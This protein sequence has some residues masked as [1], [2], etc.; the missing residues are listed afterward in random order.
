MKNILRFRLVGVMLVLV[1]VF[2]ETGA[3]GDAQPAGK[4]EG[5]SG[6]VKT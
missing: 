2:A 6:L 5:V 3:A 1:S 4:V